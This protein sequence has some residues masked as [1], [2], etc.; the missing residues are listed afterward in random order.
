MGHKVVNSRIPPHGPFNFTDQQ[1]ASGRS[2]GL[3]RVP[4]SKLTLVR[5]SLCCRLPEVWN[6]LPESLRNIRSRV[7]FKT[8]LAKLLLKEQN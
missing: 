3:Y 2:A 6:A 5:Q 7:K 4:Y 8:E 1:I